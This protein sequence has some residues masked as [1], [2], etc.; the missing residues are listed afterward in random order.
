M[1]RSTLVDDL[2]TRFDQL[3][4]GDCED[5]VTTILTALGDAMTRGNRI[6]IPGFGSFSVAERN[7]RKGRNPRSGEDVEIPGRRVVRFKPSKALREGVDQPSVTIDRRVGA[8]CLAHIP[9]FDKASNSNF[10]PF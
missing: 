9:H 4:I 1:I 7:A 8:G 5:A 3:K 6:E 10:R 2:A